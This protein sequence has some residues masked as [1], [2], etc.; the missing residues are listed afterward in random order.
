MAVGCVVDVSLSSTYERKKERKP[1]K[2]QIWECVTIWEIQTGGRFLMAQNP[3]T[4]VL[5]QSCCTSTCTCTVYCMSTGM[6]RAFE[7]IQYEFFL[8]RY[9]YQLEATL[10]G[11]VIS[12]VG[13][14]L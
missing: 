3:T 12:T 9:K 1:T 7:K 10:R 6:C 2:L 14:L 11:T 8:I 5:N 13:S 4:C